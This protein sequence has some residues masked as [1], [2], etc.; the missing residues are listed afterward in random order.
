MFEG[1]WPHYRSAEIK[2]RNNHDVKHDRF[3]DAHAWSVAEG[4][5]NILHM[6]LY[7]RL[8]AKCCEIS[9]PWYLSE[10]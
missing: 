3:A 7:F 8:R 6:Q 5:K 4:N 1:P 9:H 2:I 10:N